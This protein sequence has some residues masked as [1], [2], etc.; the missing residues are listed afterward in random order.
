[1]PGEFEETR[2]RTEA[3]A[4]R[5]AAAVSGAIEGFLTAFDEHDLATEA[6]ESMHVAGEV[7]RT[8]TQEARALVS[9]PEMRELG[10]GAQRIGAPAADTARHAADAVRSTAHDATEAVRD[11]AHA[12]RARI[13]HAADEVKLRAE[14][15]A[16]SGRRARV[17]PAR[18]G[19]ELGEAYRA[20]MRGLTTAIAMG[21]AMGVLAIVALIVLTIALV[22]GLNAL[23]GDPAGTFLVAGLY[24]VGV[25]VAFAVMRSRR[26]AAARETRER[27]ADARAHVRHVT[28]P[29]RSAFS[30][31]GRAGF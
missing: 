20:W 13:E 30:G 27:I 12:A 10:H 31:R 6:K 11:T 18:I 29:A 2:S 24:L 19:H 25:L 7:T 16:E 15:V 14:A 4:R 5:F 1:M 8:T 28:S 26:A 17:A 3:S 22:V 23:V 9:T 21:I